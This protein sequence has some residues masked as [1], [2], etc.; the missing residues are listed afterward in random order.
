MLALA[1]RRLTLLMPLGFFFS[2][3]GSQIV[4]YDPEIKCPFLQCRLPT[5]N[6]HL[7]HSI[8]SYNRS[9]SYLRYFLCRNFIAKSY[10]RIQI[11]WVKHAPLMKSVASNNF[12]VFPT[13]ELCHNDNLPGCPSALKF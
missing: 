4:Q 2:G 7:L 12:R 8:L 10:F 13:I 1:L 11:I 6:Y 5:L 9:K 3:F